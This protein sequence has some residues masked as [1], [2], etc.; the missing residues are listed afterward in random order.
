LQDTQYKLKDKTIKISEAGSI[1]KA[2]LE[3]S[4]I[5]EAAQEAA[6]IYTNAIKEKEE[7]VAQ[8][9]KEK[10]DKADAKCE[11]MLARTRRECDR[12][13][14]KTINECDKELENLKSRLTGY[15]S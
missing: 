13:R 7:K 2:S 9:L 14:E 5:F 11:E 15:K 6:D 12:M 1:A 8:E 3:L 10:Y 4:G